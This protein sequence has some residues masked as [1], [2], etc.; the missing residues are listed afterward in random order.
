MLHRLFVTGFAGTVNNYLTPE[1]RYETPPF[2]LLAEHGLAIDGFNARGGGTMR[3]DFN[4]PY[5]LEKVKQAVGG[6]IARW[7]TRRLRPWNGVVAAHLDWFAGRGLTARTAKVVRL[8]GPPAS[9]HDPIVVECA[10]A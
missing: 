1:Q 2:A 5:A 6:P 10:L 4:Q 9:D 3:Y 7:L 8:A